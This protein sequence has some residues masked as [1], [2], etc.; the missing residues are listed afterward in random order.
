MNHTDHSTCFKF[1]CRVYDIESF[2]SAM[3]MGEKPAMRLL[4]DLGTKGQTVRHLMSYLESLK[5]ENA[6]K[7][8]KPPGIFWSFVS[9][10]VAFLGRGDGV[11]Q[12]VGNQLKSEDYVKF[13]SMQQ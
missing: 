10:V 5:L 13:P 9:L 1:R 11:N 6:L 12:K 7:L 2:A 8:L 4:W 3:Y